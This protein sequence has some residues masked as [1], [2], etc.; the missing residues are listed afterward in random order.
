[1]DGD[2]MGMLRQMMENPQFGAMVQTMKTQMGDGDVDPSKVIEKLPEMMTML[3]P[4]MSGMAQGDGGSTEQA[5]KHTEPEK[6]HTEPEKEGGH[7]EPEKE[8]VHAEHPGT[9]GTMFFKP[10]SRDKR[11]KLLAALK[12]Y[13]S[14]TRCALVDRAMSAMQLGEIL[15]TM[16]PSGK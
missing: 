13:L 3:G 2:L 7:T 6:E 16:T 10:G 4:M 12:P 11:N 8:T 1:M 9:L 15:G 14:P 5:E